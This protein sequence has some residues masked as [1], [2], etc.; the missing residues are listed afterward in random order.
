MNKKQLRRHTKRIILLGMVIGFG[1]GIILWLLVSIIKDD[2]MKVDVYTVEIINGTNYYLEEVLEEVFIN[3]SQYYIKNHINVST[4][5][6]NSIET[7]VKD[8]PTYFKD[9]EY[10]E[11]SCE[12]VSNSKCSKT[13]VEWD[14]CNSGR[15]SCSM[16]CSHQQNKCYV[17][18]CGELFIAKT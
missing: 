18:K 13:A 10:L 16:S 7:R 11:E 14:E 4:N 2:T 1:I 8:Y 5:W 3:G 9:K 6:T 17:W 15:N 12:C